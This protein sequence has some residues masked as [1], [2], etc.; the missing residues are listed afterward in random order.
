MVNNNPTEKLIDVESQVALK[1]RPAWKPTKEL[2]VYCY[3]I[4]K[5]DLNYFNYVNQVFLKIS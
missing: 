1:H 4:A 5:I 3:K 2:L